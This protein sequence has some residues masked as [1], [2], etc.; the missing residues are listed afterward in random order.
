[1]K[2]TDEVYREYS[3]MVYKYLF[4]LTGDAHVAEEVTQETFYQVVLTEAAVSLH[5]FVL[6]RRIN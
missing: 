6:L 1:M 4:S 2:V 3:Q 5:G